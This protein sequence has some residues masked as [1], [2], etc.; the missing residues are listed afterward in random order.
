MTVW[1]GQWL[2]VGII[3]PWLVGV[4]MGINSSGNIN[5]EGIR[6][7]GVLSCDPIYYV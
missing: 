2:G 6:Y 4:M 1:F 3:K 7:C 5:F